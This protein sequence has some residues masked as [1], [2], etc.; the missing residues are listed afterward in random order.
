MSHA[1]GLMELKFFAASDQSTVTI[2]IPLASCAANSVRAFVNSSI[3]PL[4]SESFLPCIT[5]PTGYPRIEHLH[6]FRFFALPIIEKTPPLSYSPAT[7]LASLDAHS[8]H[9]LPHIPRPY[10]NIERK[11]QRTRTQVIT[12]R[13]HSIVRF[14]GNSNVIRS[15][16]SLRL[17]DP[18]L[19]RP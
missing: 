1:L 17:V 7:P 9:N 13:H 16:V 14:I 19:P 15:R 8:S 4:S 11:F 2:C 6:V 18:A 10:I 5:I 3:L 12:M